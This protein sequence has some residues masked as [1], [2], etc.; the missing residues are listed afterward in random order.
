MR[1]GVALASPSLREG[2]EQGKDHPGLPH[3][4]G[5]C[6]SGSTPGVQVPPQHGDIS[7]P[8]F[9]G[10]WLCCWCPGCAESC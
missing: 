7:N 5:R 8:C 10:Q 2:F 9:P 3:P 6:S 1:E 4:S